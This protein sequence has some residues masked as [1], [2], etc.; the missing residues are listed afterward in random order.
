MLKSEDKQAFGIGITFVRVEDPAG[1][2]SKVKINQLIKHGSAE[3]DGSL[4]EGDIITH[5]NGVS[6]VPPPLV[7]DRWRL[8]SMTAGRAGRRGDQELHPRRKWQQ[9]ANPVPEELKQQGGLP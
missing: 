2:G 3:V 4:K 9:R 6:L 7:V 8:T 5:V 1:E